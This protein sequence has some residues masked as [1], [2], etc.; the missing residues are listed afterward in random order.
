ME[1]CAEPLLKSVES[2]I[3]PDSRFVYVELGIAEGKTFF[4]V[5][6]HIQS[7]T[8][9]FMG[10][11]VDIINGWSLN[12]EEIN[13]NSEGI[14]WDKFQITLQGS[15][16]FLKGRKDESIDFLWIDACHARDCCMNDF[17]AAESKVKRGG[18]IGF[19]DSGELELGQDIQPHC[20]EPIGVRN[21]IKDL[22]LLQ[23]GRPGWT[24]IADVQ[25][26]P[27]GCFLVRKL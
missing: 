17:L 25:G 26:E 3:R 12:Q 11:G 24:L 9:N 22:Q 15:Q 5:L 4:G 23:E 13:K 6:K 8:E 14:P 2:L 16:D 1:I 21:A 10:Y 19:H 20:A 7:L 18:V 27:R